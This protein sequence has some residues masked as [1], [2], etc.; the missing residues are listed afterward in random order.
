MARTRASRNSKKIISIIISISPFSD[1]HHHHHHH[2]CQSNHTNSFL[3]NYYINTHH[4]K[5]NIIYA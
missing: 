5:I 3:R 4:Y 1:Y 2:H